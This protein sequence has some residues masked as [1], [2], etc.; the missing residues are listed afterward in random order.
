MQDDRG[1]SERCKGKGAQR[2][3]V[4]NTES[5]CLGK[6]PQESNANSSEETVTPRREALKD[7]QK[8]NGLTNKAFALFR[9]VVEKNVRGTN[10]AHHCKCNQPQVGKRTL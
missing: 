9:G 8:I 7:T 3:G 4:L 10:N 6:F 1:L 5:Q 2:E